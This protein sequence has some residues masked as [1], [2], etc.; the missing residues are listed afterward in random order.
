MT[1]CVARDVSGTVTVGGVPG[2][3]DYMA[4]E[5]A[6]S[7][8][9][10]GSAQSD[11]YALGLCFY[12]ALTGRPVYGRLPKDINSAWT[13]FITRVNNPPEINFEDPVF[14]DYP[15]L[16]NIVRRTLALNPSDRYSSAG[17]M[18]GALDLVLKPMDQGVADDDLLMIP[19]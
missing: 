9:D 17:E 12:E 6:D 15:L 1:L 8:G 16:A 14:K 18:S 7:T 13:G 4:P 19:L 11:L 2:T 10:R 3:L 5:F